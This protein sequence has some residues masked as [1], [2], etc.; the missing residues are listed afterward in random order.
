MITVRV[1]RIIESETLHLPELRS[2]IGKNVEI[3]IRDEPAEPLVAPGTADWSALEKAAKE[4]EDYDFDA[5]RNQR[6]YDL[7][8]AEDHL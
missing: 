1:R 5:F 2:M 6:D 7:R 4:L 8:H 3:T